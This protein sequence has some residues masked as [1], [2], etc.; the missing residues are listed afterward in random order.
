[1]EAGA[2]SNDRMRAIVGNA[3]IIGAQSI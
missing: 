1:V 2:T 3:R